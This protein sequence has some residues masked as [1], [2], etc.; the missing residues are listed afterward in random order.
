MISLTRF[1]KPAIQVKRHSAKLFSLLLCAF[2]LMCWGN[3]L[4]INA[5][6]SVAQYLIADAWQQTLHTGQHTRPWAWA[7]TWPVAKLV[8]PGQ[9]TSLYVLSGSH[10]TS[11]AFGPGHADG[12]ALPGEPG[13]AVIHGHRDTHFAALANLTIGDILRVQIR[14]GIW[15]QYTIADIFVVDTRTNNWSI[16]PTD[17]ALYLITC[18]PFDDLNVNPPLRYIVQAKQ[19]NN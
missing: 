1:Q 11:L 16:N 9:A 12:T 2:V 7:D 8:F 15:I 10:G 3:T 18:Y 19:L 17:E 6:A 13:T 5:K 14:S 4:W